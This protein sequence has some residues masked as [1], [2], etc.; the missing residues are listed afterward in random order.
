MRF[1]VQSQLYHQGI[2]NEVTHMEKEI[3]ATVNHLEDYGCEYRFRPGQTVFLR[4]DENNP[5]DDEAV[6]VHD[7]SG[8]KCGYVANSVSTVARGTF[9]AGRL[10]GMIRGER[11]ARIEFIL[12]GVLIVKLMD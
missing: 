3:Y 4:R 6:S 12:D 5:Y 8:N 2:R 11:E 9:S 7:D 10:L 1:F